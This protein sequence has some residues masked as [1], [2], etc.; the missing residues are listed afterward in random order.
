ML[1]IS[2]YESCQITQPL[3]VTLI[4]WVAVNPELAIYL[5]KKQFSSSANLPR[6]QNMLAG[7]ESRVFNDCTEWMLHKDIFHSGRNHVAVMERI[8]QE[9]VWCLL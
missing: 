3:F 8:F 7:R 5:G 9:L 1:E 2:T 6:K 4:I